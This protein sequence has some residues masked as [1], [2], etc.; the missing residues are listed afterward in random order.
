MLQKK[1][2]I[3]SECK[4]SLVDLDNRFKRQDVPI[5]KK[6][7]RTRRKI[8]NFVNENAGFKSG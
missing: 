2:D 7:K 4:S 5:S 6:V 1:I 3:K 8:R